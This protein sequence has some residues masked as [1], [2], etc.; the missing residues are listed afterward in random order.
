MGLSYRYTILTGSYAPDNVNFRVN[1][2]T[3]S[4]GSPGTNITQGNTISVSTS[5]S[6]ALNLTGGVSYAASIIGMDISSTSP[7]SNYIFDIVITVAMLNETILS[8]SIYSESSTHPHD[9]ADLQFCYH[10]QWAVQPGQLHLLHFRQS[11]LPLPLATP[12]L[13]SYMTSP[14]S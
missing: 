7:A 11:Q 5:V 9:Q 14:L 6:P 13:G 12:T 3:L 10:Q 8:I 1:R 2:L 4:G